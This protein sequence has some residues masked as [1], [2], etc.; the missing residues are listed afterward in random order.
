M[1]KK[2]ILAKVGTSV[3]SVKKY[4][5][6]NNLKS[7]DKIDEVELFEILSSIF[8][9]TR[10]KLLKQKDEINNA[11]EKL[12]ED[13]KRLK[14]EKEIELKEE[15]DKKRADF[16]IE[17]LSKKEEFLKEEKEKFN[18]EL[19]KLSQ[20]IV[21]LENKEKNLLQ[22]EELL[23][24]RIKTFESSKQEE[25][26]KLQEKL[27][28]Q[29]EE[30][31]VNLKEKEVK[32]IEE[33]NKKIKE[34]YKNKE[35]ELEQIK[36]N[37]N[38]KEIN[39]KAQE[40]E[41]NILKKELEQKE[42]S[43]EDKVNEAIEQKIKNYENK[44]E[45]LEEEIEILREE[46]DEL[47][48]EVNA[49]QRNQDKDI[50]KELENKRDELREK[51]KY[52]KNLIEEKNREIE[53]LKNNLQE[54]KEKNQ[55]ILVENEK[56]RIDIEEV[57]RIKSQNRILEEKLKNL[58]FIKGENDELRKKLEAIYS[59]GEEKDLRIKN[60]EKDLY[61]EKRLEHK[62]EITDEIQ[63]LENIQNNMKQYGVK[64][65]KRLLYAFH[66]ALKSAS[67]SPLTVLAGVSGTGKSELPKLY[68][69]FGGFNFLAEAVQPNW[70]SP[71]SMMGYYNTLENK[72]DATNI[73]K[74][75]VQTSLSKDE[76]EFG[77]K[78]SMNMI[79]LDEMN[80]AH[81]ELYFAE[82]LSKF[83]QKRGSKD[84]YIDIKLGAGYIH[85]ILLD[86]N[87]L[88]IGTMNEDE[89]TK[90]LSDKVLDRSFVINFPRPTDL[91]SRN[92]LVSLDEISEFKYLDKKVWESWIQKENLIKDDKKDVIREFKDITNKINEYLSKTGRAIGHRVW[93]SMEF[94]INNHPEVIQ[95]INN[96]DELKKAVKIAFEEQLVQK[97]MPKLRGIETH[98]KEKEV[99]NFIKELLSKNDFAIVQDFENAM[100]NP[101]GQFIW[102]SAEYLK[103]D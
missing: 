94:Y 39:L 73:L 74:F 32:K 68:A 50:L 23:N 34:L 67:F 8:K 40:K 5:A 76:N 48:D 84:V 77:Y 95:N 6:T 35:K 81:I 3:D 101:Y 30:F 53:I 61:A 97:I 27:K 7:Y 24:Q 83:E 12:K 16:E 21:E 38:E 62:H 26:N 14:T 103:V 33:I 65:P 72:F 99:L 70:D 63:W 13:I 25:F 46:R 52:Y 93:Q 54:L 51:E 29:E 79:L 2:E 19:Q 28:L 57:E 102:N 78:E 15:L 82:F 9:E 4:I 58:E 1:T 22:K 100:N 20:K 92:K 64:Y 55:E 85:N 66:T 10:E 44:I 49:L 47:L 37:L 80:L 91:I 75:L 98:G 96:L 31:N 59:T 69:H 89:T 11:K 43:F 56:L 60:L 42:N 88:W 86:N 41:L 36:N 45:R 17:L 71:E 87:L 90:A 18:K